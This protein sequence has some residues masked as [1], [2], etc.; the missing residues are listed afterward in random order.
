MGRGKDIE[1]SEELAKLVLDAVGIHT[2]GLDWLHENVDRFPARQTV[3]KWRNEHPDFDDAYMRVKQRQVLYA[4]EEAE[5]VAV[6]G[7]QDYTIDDKGHKVVDHEH[8]S[9]SRLIV[10]TRKWMASKLVPRLF[11][12]KQV[13]EQHNYNHESTLKDLDL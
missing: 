11:G 5:D 8:I 2:K 1:Y 12:D 9:R 7:S 13:V 10:D 3:Y 4:A 6:D